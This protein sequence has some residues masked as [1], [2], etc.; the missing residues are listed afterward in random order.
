[1]IILIALLLGTA[2]GVGIRHAYGDSA[3]LAER[4][5]AGTERIILED[6]IKR[7]RA[8]VALHINKETSNG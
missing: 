8:Q 2:I 3:R 7:L 5:T 6:E 1:M 4:E